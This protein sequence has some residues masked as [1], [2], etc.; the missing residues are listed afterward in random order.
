MKTQTSLDPLRKHIPLW[1]NRK[2]ANCLQIQYTDTSVLCQPWQQCWRGTQKGIQEACLRQLW[3]TS[4]YPQSL[5][6]KHCALR[7]K[8]FEISLLVCFL[9][10]AVFLPLKT[11][12]WSFGSFLLLSDSK[13]KRLGETVKLPKHTKKRYLPVLYLLRF[14]WHLLSGHLHAVLCMPVRGM[15][16]GKKPLANIINKK[17]NTP[18]DLGLQCTYINYT[19]ESKASVCA[20]I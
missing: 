7:Y 14:K 3:K 13:D 5:R 6:V 11:K 10:H 16:E 20:S 19:P 8:N 17:W 4:F 12:C 2:A 9:P 15:L 1:E 18:P